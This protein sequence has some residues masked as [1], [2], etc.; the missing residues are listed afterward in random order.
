MKKPVKKNKLSRNKIY[1]LSGTAV[2]FLLFLWYVISGLPG[3]EELENPDPHFATKV[4]SVDGELV[5]QFYIEN[6]IET[7]IDSLP[8]H[9][10]DALIATEDRK[11]YDHWG[12]DLDRFIKAMIKNVFTFSREGASTI[13]QQLAKNLYQLKGARENLF[14][15]GVRKLREWFTAIQIERT[16]T[17][18]EILE[19]YLNISYFGK[20][21]YGVETAAQIYFDKK[22]SELSVTESALLIAILKSSVY[23]DPERRP[24]SAKQRRNVVMYN[25]VQQQVLSQAEYQKL[26]EEPVILARGQ[27]VNIKTV[28]PHF[29]EY[30]RQE[31]QQLIAEK[32]I[33]ADLYRDGLTIYTTLDYQMQVIAN[34]VAKE[35][36]I[37]YQQLFNKNWKW[38]RNQSL[39]NSLIERAAKNSTLY[40]TAE[41]DQEKRR[42][43]TLLKSDPEFVD[44]VKKAE[45]TMQVGFVVTDPSSGEIRAMV[46][47]ENQDFLYGLNH[48]TQIRRQPGSSFKPLVYAV[49]VD[50]GCSPEQLFENTPFEYEGWSPRNSDGEYGGTMTLREALARSINVVAGRLTTSDYAPPKQVVKLAKDMGINSDLRAFPS[51]ALGTS[52]ITPLELAGA[53]GTIA[54]GGVY[55][56]PFS[57]LRVED[58]NGIVI[59]EPKLQKKNALS[60][61]T[62]A[63]VVDMMQDVVNWGTGAGV[64]RH[65]HRPAAGKTGTT[66]DFS[67]AWFGGFTPQLLGV[68][69]VGFDD[70]RVKFSGW[71][72]QG[73]KAAMPVW[74]KFM[75]E[76]YKTLNLPLKYFDVPSGVSYAE[77]CKYAVSQGTPQLANETCPEVVSDI[78]DDENPPG[79]C[80]Y[81]PGPP[82]R[83]GMQADTQNKNTSG[84]SGW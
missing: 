2:L 27:K 30:I 26:K 79:Q 14:D 65:F 80:V 49:A 77:F 25:M 18:K 46:G 35:H 8:K 28:A 62:A 69:W 58:R 78:I 21:A 34:K 45:A 24:E 72:G 3:L 16:F 71:Y 43:L 74:A 22:A 7:D 10:I 57:I 4:Y 31:M 81:H 47:G 53:Y 67:D 63:I 33:S 75:A 48:V 50:N 73:A 66:Q 11:F 61:R 37:E 23:Y 64:R 5:G 44:S 40:R 51:I 15:T 42:I 70:H 12:V 68:V 52:E 29:L 83:A 38:E 55:M 54:N 9:L 32:R 17:K 13:T 20:G 76:T 60:P 59:Y 84:G 39:L 36:L 19:L 82:R 6:R 1:L 41:S 56:R